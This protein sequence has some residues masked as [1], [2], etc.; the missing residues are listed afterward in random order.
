MEIHKKKL[1]NELGDR[2]WGKRR[3]IGGN[4][5]NLIE[6]NNVKYDW[7][8]RMYRTMMNNFWIPEEVPLAQDAKDYKNLSSA[9][10]QSYDKII[11]FLI[12]LDSLQ[13]TNLPNIN[14]FI[15]APEVNLCI[16]VQTFQEAV[17]SQ[18]YSYI[19]DSV[20]SADVRD[21]I[22]NQWREDQ[23][24]L[25]RNRFI[26][27]LYERFIE[28]PTEENLLR[29]IMANYILEGIYFY[30]GFSFFYCLG[31]QGKM[32]GTVSVIKYIQRD[33]LTHL[34]LFQGIMRE[35]RK[36]NPH[37]FTPQFT[38]ELRG[39]MRTAVEHEIS[40][41]QYITQNQIE[42]L[43]DEIIELY[44]KYL[45]NQRMQ[46]LGFEVLYPEVTEHP[47]KWVESFSN[48][49]GIKTDF[50]EQKVTTYSKS[51]NLNWDEL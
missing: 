44:I 25:K 20:C 39:M 15:T 45:S 42:G 19:L 17:H 29:T 3:I 6:L 41:G 51:A 9:E 30:S 47:M 37:L 28:Q 34:S 18:S 32:L 49:N 12:F 43:S 27:D 24:L 40:W 7:A 1:F 11:S 2:D 35:V 22:Y 31:R 26:T 8:T 14:D 16:T 33:E 36:E 21:Q 23:H 50:F 46:K 13:T 4:T 10:R 5:T 38:E 48:M